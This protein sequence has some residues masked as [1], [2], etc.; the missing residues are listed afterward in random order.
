[1][2][3]FRLRTLKTRVLS[4]IEK[5]ASSLEN[6]INKKRILNPMDLSNLTVAYLYL[7][8]ITGNE[9]YYQKSLVILKDILKRQNADGSWNEIYPGINSKS[10]LATAYIGCNLL[11]LTIIDGELATGTK[12]SVL[13]ASHYVAK[14]ELAPGY[15]LKS[16]INDNDTVN[17]NMICSLYFLRLYKYAGVQEF[18]R[19]ADRTSK[20]VIRSQLSSGAFPYYTDKK[21]HLAP[22]HYHAFMTKLLSEYLCL[23][24]DEDVK[25]SLM[26]AVS[27][28]IRRFDDAGKISWSGDLGIWTYRSFSDYGYAFYGLLFAGGF[29]E[30]FKAWSERVF[31][32]MNRNQLQDGSFPAIDNEKN[33]GEIRADIT[34]V[35]RLISHRDFLAIL[36]LFEVE[37]NRRSSNVSFEKVTANTQLL[38]ALTSSY[39][40]FL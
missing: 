4:S 30:Y 22:I 9:F 12:R 15:F 1:M 17:V 32:Y 25:A 28:L 14:K 16:E 6:M 7:G 20:R 11:K 34:N 36:S 3:E 35:I 10:T 33:M 27:W 23:T 31:L 21:S 19:I 37:F 13:E 18:L 24:F 38:E 26:K 2:S 40:A 39:R 5:L 8:E 29:D